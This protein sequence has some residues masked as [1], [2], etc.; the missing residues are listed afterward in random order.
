[1]VCPPSWGLVSYLVSQLVS[2]LVP[3]VARGLI[4]HF[5][6]NSVRYGVLNF[7]SG[8]VF[9]PVPQKHVLNPPSVWGLRWSFFTTAAGCMLF[10]Q[11]FRHNVKFQ[12]T[13]FA[14][15]AWTILSYLPSRDGN[16][17]TNTIFANRHPICQDLNNSPILMKHIH[18]TYVKKS[19]YIYI[20][21]HDICIVFAFFIETWQTVS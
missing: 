2:L 19:I 14:Y 15:H 8:H 6:P 1:M 10:R 11:N 12:D 4:L 9:Y 18:M 17:S 13:C 3:F 5:F 20:Y 7:F 16:I 21:T